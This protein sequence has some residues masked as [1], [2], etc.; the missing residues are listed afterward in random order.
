MSESDTNNCNICSNQSR[1]NGQIL[2]LEKNPDFENIEKM[3]I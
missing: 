1:E 3:N 2:I